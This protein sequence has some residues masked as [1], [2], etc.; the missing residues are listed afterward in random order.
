MRKAS[1]MQ[2]K[3]PK[4]PAGCKLARNYWKTNDVSIDFLLP[5]KKNNFD[6]NFDSVTVFDAARSCTRCSWARNRKPI[7]NSMLMSKMR[8]P[9]ILVQNCS[10]LIDEHSGAENWIYFSSWRVL[11]LQRKCA[12]VEPC[13]TQ[14]LNTYRNYTCLEE[15]RKNAKKCFFPVFPCFLAFFSPRS[16]LGYQ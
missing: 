1:S 4:R 5:E 2:K 12:V 8:P 14:F 3:Q 11:F 9:D 10:F 13:L 6:C 7:S 16:G 15:V